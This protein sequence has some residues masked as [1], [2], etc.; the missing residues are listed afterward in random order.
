MIYLINFI[1]NNGTRIYN[2][3]FILCTLAVAWKILFFHVTSVTS[4]SQTFLGGSL[5]AVDLIPA[6]GSLQTFISNCNIVEL[7][8]N[9]LC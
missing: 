5:Q 3:C 2:L 6:V 7:Y 8:N 1:P 9:I 4:K